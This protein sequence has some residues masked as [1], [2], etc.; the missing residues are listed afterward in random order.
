MKI[1]NDLEH[2]TRKGRI[3]TICYLLLVKQYS[4]GIVVDHACVY[5]GEKNECTKRFAQEV[6][7][8]VSV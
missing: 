6:A 1:F 8:N 4:P 7:L 5:V 2:N 3:L